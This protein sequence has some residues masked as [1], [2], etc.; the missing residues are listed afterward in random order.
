MDG[1]L[2]LDLQQRLSIISEQKRSYTMGTVECI[3]EQWIFF[4]ADTDEASMLEDMINKEAQVFTLQKWEKGIFV[5]DGLLQMKDFY[6]KLSNGDC[7]RFR[8]VLPYSY[9][10]L[11]SSFSEE[12][13][14]KYT[15]TLNKLSFSLYDC[16]YCHNQLLYKPDE[17]E[18]S[19]V[20]FIT[21]D[22]TETICTVQHFFSRGR[23]KK[24][25]FEFTLSNGQRALLT[26]LPK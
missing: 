8:K 20:N 14:I 13:F 9:S 21:Y 24:D 17:R 12:L 3:N 7:I 18:F 19:G 1:G 16:E 22:N 6:Y 11:L 26:I 2:A 23:V 5:E 4:D 15:T 10:E 25:R